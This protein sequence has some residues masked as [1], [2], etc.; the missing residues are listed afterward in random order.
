MRKFIYIIVFFSF[1]DLFTQLPIMSPFAESLGAAP[2]LTG[3]IVG[4]YSF[5]NTIG[6]ILSGF[7][8]DRKGPFI[9]LVSGLFAASIS[10]FLYNAADNAWVLLVIRFV[11]GLMAGFI[12]PAAF[13]YLANATAN[14]KKGK[15]AAISGAFVGLAAIIGPAFSGII[16]SRTSETTVLTVNAVIMLLLGV[17]A[18]YFL[19]ANIEAAP[20]QKDAPAGIFRHPDVLKAFTGAFLLMFSQGVMAYMLPLKVIHLGYDTKTSGLL[21][22]TFGI[23]AIL[24]FLLPT[25]RLFDVLKPVHT[26]SFGIA[27]MGSSLILLGQ[28]ASPGALYFLMGLYGVGFAFLFPSINSLLVGAVEPGQRGKA[29][30]Y[31]YAFFSLGVVAGSGVTG[32]LALSASG[33]FLLTGLILISAAIFVTIHYFLKTD[34]T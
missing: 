11:H 4:M 22:S 34:A 13:T 33:G 25:N 19:R 29:Y 28:A 21:L 20:R 27:M 23:V 26:F 14:E 18:V 8:T 16:A 17:L 24:V 3:F 10:L 15:G 9:V 12:T 7:I 2:F 6:N 5:S 1:F 30:G 31:F 32:L